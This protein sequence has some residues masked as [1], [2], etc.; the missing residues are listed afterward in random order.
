MYHW[1]SWADIVGQSFDYYENW[2]ECGSGNSL[3]LSRVFECNSINNFTK[4][5]T[6]LIMLSS[7]S[8]LDFF[9]KNGWNLT[10]NI[11]NSHKE[12]WEQRWLDNN[13]SMQYSMYE[14]C[15]RLQSVK[16]F[17]D[18]IGCEYKIM[19][20]FDLQL[21]TLGDSWGCSNPNFVN[22]DNVDYLT[23]YHA[24]GEQ[25]ILDNYYSSIVKTHCD[26]IPSLQSF[27]EDR[28]ERIGNEL[29]E[30]S[31]GYGNFPW[32]DYHPTVRQHEE[33]CRMYLSKFYK[34][35]VNVS[36]LESIINFDT[37]WVDKPEQESLSYFN[38]DTFNINLG[39]RILP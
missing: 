5:D 37:G 36:Q 24:Y 6:I 34:N 3:I 17:L 30:F 1:P 10:G 20:A 22:M 27:Q 26:N 11:L 29:Y 25:N 19:K 15:I 16:Y 14:L 35:F 8:R 13:W 23:N 12:D 9:G 31:E 18:C 2:G 21:D 4:N 39:N 33:F 28:R 7:L 38:T 32:V